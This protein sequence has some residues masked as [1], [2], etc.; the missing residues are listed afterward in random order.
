MRENLDQSTMPDYA[1]LELEGGDVMSSIAMTPTVSKPFNSRQPASLSLIGE[2]Q[3]GQ[4]SP[5]VL[6]KKVP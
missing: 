4:D 3:L 5:N 2:E 1:G 6:L